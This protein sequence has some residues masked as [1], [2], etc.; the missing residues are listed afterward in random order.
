[1]DCLNSST[2]AIR[3]T[4]APS[5]T[6]MPTPTRP[7]AARFPAGALPPL[8]SSSSTAGGATITSGVSP[9]LMRLRI[10]GAVA[11]A[12]VTLWPVSRWKASISRTKP[13]STAPALSTLISAAND[14]PATIHAS[15]AVHIKSDFTVL[16]LRDLHQGHGI[17]QTVCQDEAA[18]PGDRSVAH[19]VAATRDRPALELR[20]LG[21]EPHD[22]VRARPGL[23]VPD[24][25]VDGRDA[26]RLRFRPA[27]RRPFGHRSSRG[28]EPPEIAA[29]KIGVPDDVV[30]GDR[31][32]A[33]SRRRVRQRVLA[34]APP[35]RRDGPR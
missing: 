26:V 34:N 9:S 10:A 30:T 4:G 29:R 15:A 3:G 18:V 7:T 11:K 20:A 21:I 5:R 17:D 27:R 14:P 6:A 2:V 35:R 22:R 32:A 23:A 19:D 1:M 12:A 8:T 13:G 31:D 24:D 33:R 16:S 25:V 28:I